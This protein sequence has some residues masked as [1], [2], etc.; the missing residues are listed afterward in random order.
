MEVQA[1][2]PATAPAQTEQAAGSLLDQVINE[3]KVARSDSERARARDLIGELVSQVLEGTVIVSNNLSATLD[4]RVAELDALISD[5]LSAIMHAPAFQKM[6]STWRGLHYL[7]KQTATGETLKIKLLHAPKKDLVRDF[8][9]AID[10]DQS[11]LFKKVY[12][13]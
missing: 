10:F 11:A 3:S 7:C 12:E 4:A 13:E 2:A 1:L 8:A 5:Q 9:N 6:E